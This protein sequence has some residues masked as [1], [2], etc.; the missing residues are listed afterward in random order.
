M[1]TSR[2]LYMATGVSGAREDF[3]FLFLRLHLAKCVPVFAF[4]VILPVFYLTS[5][6]LFGVRR[7]EGAKGADMTNVKASER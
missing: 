6:S 4:L 1:C 3:F 5:V 7:R 2:C